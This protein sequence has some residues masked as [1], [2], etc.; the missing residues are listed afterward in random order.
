M[1][2]AQT[3][4]QATIS[5]SLSGCL[6][7]GIII[8]RFD[9]G[10]IGFSYTATHGH[11]KTMNIKIKFVGIVFSQYMDIIHDSPGEKLHILKKAWA[12]HKVYFFL[13]TW[14]FIY[15]THSFITYKLISQFSIYLII[16]CSLLQFQNFFPL[17]A[18]QSNP[19]SVPEQGVIWNRTLHFIIPHCAQTN[20]Q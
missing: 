8:S 7:K 10:K 11:V 6:L 12:F 18:T 4:K 17:A 16:A 9:K 1:S 5:F 3:R 2:K 19:I 13:I 15:S 14:I 20:F